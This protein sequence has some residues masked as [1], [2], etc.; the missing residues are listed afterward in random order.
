MLLLLIVAVLVVGLELQGGEPWQSFRASAISALSEKGILPAPKKKPES[1]QTIPKKKKK[2]RRRQRAKRPAAA[3]QA[4]A[5]DW[6]ITGEVYDLLTLNPISNATLTFREDPTK[7]AVTAK[8]D[9]L[10]QFEVTL[11][12][13]PQA[14]YTPSFFH[15]DFDK[16]F[17]EESRAPYK[18]WSEDRRRDAFAE[19]LT[20]EVLHVPIF[21]GTQGTLTYNIAALP[22][23]GQ[24]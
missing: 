18:R 9:S 6:I 11:P 20:A 3:A 10:G 22:K 23:S 24:L 7:P 17:L 21:V 5:E 2:S 8:T 14:G 19:A 16:V 12:A 1:G 13:L 4:P 15:P